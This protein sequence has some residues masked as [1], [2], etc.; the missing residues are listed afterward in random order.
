VSILSPAV[1]CCHYVSEANL[2]CELMPTCCIAISPSFIARLCNIPVAYESLL[3]CADWSAGS[4]LLEIHASY[5]ID[6]QCVR[7][8]LTREART[9]YSRFR[10]FQILGFGKVE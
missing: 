3:C 5:F 6:S 10:F 1:F 7:T 8:P 2:E 9:S 4:I